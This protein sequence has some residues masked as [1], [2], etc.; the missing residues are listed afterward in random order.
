MTGPEAPERSESYAVAIAQTTLN[1]SVATGF[2]ASDFTYPSVLILVDL[3]DLPP[4]I[5]TT[6]SEN[7]V[8]HASL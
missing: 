6:Y 4:L 8:H 7:Y 1:G 5:E 3:T 2:I